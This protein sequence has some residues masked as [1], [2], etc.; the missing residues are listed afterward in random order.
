MAE[1]E[2]TEKRW[3]VETV[4]RHSSLT[5]GDQCVGAARGSGDE[6]PGEKRVWIQEEK[7]PVWQREEKGGEG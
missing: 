6:V 7:H 1:K 5:E 4:P 3:K 2:G